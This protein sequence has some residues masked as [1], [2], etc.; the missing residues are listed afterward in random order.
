M[1]QTQLSQCRVKGASPR[2]VAPGP[3]V[4]TMWTVSGEALGVGQCD[5]GTTGCWD[6]PPTS[7]KTDS[8]AVEKVGTIN[9]ENYERKNIHGYKDWRFQLFID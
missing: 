8:K 2:L 7:I 6:Y 9:Y 4:C 3:P 5:T 1:A